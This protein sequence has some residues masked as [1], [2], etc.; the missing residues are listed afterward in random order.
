MATPTKV[1]SALKR[2][3]AIADKNQGHIPFKHPSPLLQS[4]TFKSP[5][6]ARI[7]LL[8]QKYRS[9]VIDHFPE[10]PGLPQNTQTYLT[11]VNELY[12]YDAYNSLSIEGYQVTPELIHRVANNHWNPE[13]HQEDKQQR[14]A[15]AARGYY[16]AF[17]LVNK[18]LDKILKGHSPGET[19]T[20]DLSQ[21]YYHLFA[22]SLRAGLLSATD[23]VGY[24]NS[25]VYIRN[26]RHAP[27]PKEA[28]LDCMETFFHC[29]QQEPVPSVRAVL[30]HYI[31][32]FIHPYMDGNGRIARFILNTML[33]S[34]GYPWTIVQ[35]QRRKD[36]IN[37]LENT[38]IKE[39]IHS[40]C[41]FI[42]EEM[43]L[44]EPY[45]S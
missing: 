23:L 5:H 6:G 17:Q 2:V 22:P 25:Q 27:P 26:S 11:T 13:T 16:E 42:T 19:I 35:V 21:W 43:A 14:D 4:T 36:Y 12:E 29:L 7:E 37:S 32:V 28:V 30:G 44:S 1:A 8:W 38:H 41:T 15:L 45:F 10:S 3:Q 9:T 18:T 39:D 33:A 24:R 20:K 40:F 31:F 34:G